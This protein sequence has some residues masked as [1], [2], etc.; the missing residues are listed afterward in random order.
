MNQDLLGRKNNLYWMPKTNH[1]KLA[2]L[3]RKLRAGKLPT[4]EEVMDV[5]RPE[6]DEF[7]SG[8]KKT[9]RI[10]KEDLMRPMKC[11]VM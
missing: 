8:K 6:E 10:A 3:G 1:R 9:P 7:D 11:Q 4:E 5:L 2:I